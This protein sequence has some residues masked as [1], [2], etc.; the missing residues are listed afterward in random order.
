MNSSPMQIDCLIPTVLVI[1]AVLV[2]AILFYVSK[3][4]KS[5]G[6]GRGGSDGDV[7]HV[8]R[9]I[10]E[11]QVR[12]PLPARRRGRAARDRMIRQPEEQDVIEQQEEEYNYDTGN[13]R[14]IGAKKARKLEMKEE[15]RAQREQDLADREESKRRQEIIEEQRIKDAEKEQ[16][17]QHQIEEE[18]K[19]KKEEQE[20]KELEEYCALKESFEVHEEGFEKV[21]DESESHNLLQ[22]FISYIKMKKVVL[23]EDLGAEFNMKTQDAIQRV[24]ELQDQDLI[25]GVI[26]DRGKYIFISQDELEGV[27]RFMRQR[28]RVSISE[29][30]EAS[31]TLILFNTGTKSTLKETLVA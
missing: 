21:L 10:D 12:V 30:A 6:G 31:N 4:K 29:L 11:A 16:L 2:G 13:T 3:L 27:A 22:E 24:Q 18:E 25:T 26:D 23:L 14:R 17:A 8:E 1:I 15:K 7:R 20:Q 9:D 19:K 5:A 28:G